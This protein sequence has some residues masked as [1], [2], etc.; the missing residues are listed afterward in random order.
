MAIYDYYCKAI[1]CSEYP[2]ANQEYCDLHKG[3]GLQFDPM[4]TKDDYID[5]INSMSGCNATGLIHSMDNLREKIWNT[6]RHHG[7]G[8]EWVNA[9]PI[10]Q[11]YAYQLAHLC[12]NRE[13]IEWNGF[14]R[15]YEFCRMVVNGVY[16]S[17]ADYTKPQYK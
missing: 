4:L 10:L 2:I 17:D 5:C 12:H 16:L 1:G 11:L 15:A 6:A 9:H 3:E 13:P 7:K 8:T 14:H